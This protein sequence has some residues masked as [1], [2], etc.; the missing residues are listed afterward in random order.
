MKKFSIYFTLDELTRTNPEI[1]KRYGIK[2]EPN[3]QQIENLQRIA[4][5]ILDPL[6][7]AIGKPLYVSSGYRNLHYNKIIGGAPSSQHT[8]GEAVDIDGDVT[9]VSNRLIFEE[10]KKLPFDQ[11]IWEFGDKEP[12]WVH[13]SLRKEKNRGNILKAVRANG[14]TKYITFAQEKS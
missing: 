8:I 4:K 5:T 12:D 10:L 3:A 1:L 14:V 7:E 13:V 6:R 2:N 9:G 11:I